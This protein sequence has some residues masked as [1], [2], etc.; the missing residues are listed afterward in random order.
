MPE[1]AAFKFYFFMKT[2]LSYQGMTAEKFSV[3]KIPESLK[4]IGKKIADTYCQV[5]STEIWNIHGVDSTLQQIDFYRDSRG[6]EKKDDVLRIYDCLNEL[7]AML[8]TR[9]H[10]VKNSPYF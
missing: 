4:T 5:S 1:L 6:F 7:V 8:K 2:I 3:D 10:Q 9:L